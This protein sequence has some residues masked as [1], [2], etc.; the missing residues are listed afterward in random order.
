[1]LCFALKYHKPIDKITVDKNLPKLRKYQLTDAEWMV[2]RELITVLKCYKQATLYFSWNLATTAGVIPAMD[3]L[4][5]HLKSAGMDEALHPAIWAAM[6]LACNK[7]DQY[8]RKTDDSNVYHITMV[9]HP[10]LKL[11]YF[12]T[13]DREEEWVKVAENLTHEE[14]V[15]NYKDKVP[16]PAQKNTA[17]KVQ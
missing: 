15:D 4:D 3:R 6:K 8:W 10:G 1:M 12:R 17:K 2:L 5:N 14:Y 9:L 16:P 7:M 13:Q 11:Q